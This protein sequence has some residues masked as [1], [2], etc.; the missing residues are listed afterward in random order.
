[1]YCRMFTKFVRVFPKNVSG[2]VIEPNP[3]NPSKAL[4]RIVPF[5][6]YENIFFPDGN[7]GTLGP[8]RP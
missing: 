1:M 6:V 4:N 7:S 5:G 2:M 8:L 3:Q